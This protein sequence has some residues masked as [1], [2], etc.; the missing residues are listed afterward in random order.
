MNRS[1]K[2]FENSSVIYLLTNLVT[3]WKGGKDNGSE[4]DA[5]SKN[6]SRQA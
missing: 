4:I 5:A 2:D 1:F 3:T 6:L